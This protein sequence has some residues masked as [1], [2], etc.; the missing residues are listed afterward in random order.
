MILRTSSERQR[1]IDMLGRDD[2]LGDADR[3]A[4]LV[5]HRD[6]ALGIGA[7]LDGGALPGLAGFGQ[8]FEDLVGVVDRG[9]QQLGG[10][11]ARIAEHD[12]LVAGADVLVALLVDA[13][14]DI[15]RLAVQQHV[16]LGT[17]SS[18]SRPARSRWRL[19]ALRAVD[20]N[21]AGLTIGRAGRVVQDVAVLVLLEQRFGDADFAGDDDAVGGGQRLAG[22]ADLAGV[23]AGLLGFAEDQVDDLVGNPVADL[24]RMTLGNRF[25]SEEIG[26]PHGRNPQKLPQ[27]AK[28][29]QFGPCFCHRGGWRSRRI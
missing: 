4:V 22:D 1:G 26:R 7:E 13:L 5:F 27:N 8:D 17:S 11:A 20:L 18:G 16:D 24:V 6:L 12:A 25:R 21:L 29:A 28:I 19:M 9:G 23:H 3:H 10:L 2:D 15:G 14:R